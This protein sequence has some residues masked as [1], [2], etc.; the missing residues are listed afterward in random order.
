MSVNE[1]IEGQAIPPAGGEVLD[2]HLRVTGNE[3]ERE[4]ERIER[5]K[6]K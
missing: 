1:G 6:E 2:V 5:V 4:K 3:D